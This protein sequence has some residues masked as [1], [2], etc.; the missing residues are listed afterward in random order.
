MAQDTD[1][2]FGVSVAFLGDPMGLDGVAD[3]ACVGARL[4]DDGGGN[5]GAVYILL[6]NVNGTVKAE[7]KISSTQGGLTGLLDGGDVCGMNSQPNF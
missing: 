5:R 6:L 2:F 4:D 7:Q 1:K 3:L